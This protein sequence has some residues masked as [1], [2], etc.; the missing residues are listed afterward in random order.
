MGKSSDSESSQST[1][2]LWDL[3]K[4][5]GPIHGRVLPEMRQFRELSDDD[6]GK[7]VE[8]DLRQAQD[9]HLITSGEAQ[10][11]RQIAEAFRG[12]TPAAELQKAVRTTYEELVAQGLKASPM[13]VV[14]VSVALNTVALGPGALGV[15]H[16]RMAL[17]DVAGAI[18]GAVGGAGFGPA[19]A[20]AGGIAGGVAL[21]L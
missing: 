9:Q 1:V 16:W 6:L 3:A 7:R 13:A 14:V 12:K 21:S 11:I 10:Q 5:A 2:S 15:F 17:K 20:V 4:M 18:G 8:R 19:G